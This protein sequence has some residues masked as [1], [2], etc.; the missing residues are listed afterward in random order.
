MAG[1]MPGV[2]AGSYLLARLSAT[3]H[4]GSLFAVLGATITLMAGLNLYRLLFPRPLAK[5][6]RFIVTSDPRPKTA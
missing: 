3:Q 1:G 6:R 5:A 4:R 2:L